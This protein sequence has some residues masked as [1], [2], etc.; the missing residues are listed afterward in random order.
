MM[1]RTPLQIAA[2]TTLA[3]ACS[4]CNLFDRTSPNAEQF[5]LT[6]QPVAVHEGPSL[7]SVVV[8]RVLIQRPFDARGFV[9]RMA[10]GQWRVDAYNGFLA[11]PSDMIADAMARAFEGSRRFSMVT[12]A[13]VAVP[14]DLAAEAVVESFHCDYSDPAKPVAV[15]RMRMYILA[16]NEGHAVRAALESSASAPVESSSPSAVAAALSVAVARALDGAV[17]QLPKAASVASVGPDR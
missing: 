17:S 14:T 4:G 11:D 16:R 5:M 15:V 6:P 7:G 3:L 9:Y 8:R 10:N 12:T 2:A 1:N 13:A